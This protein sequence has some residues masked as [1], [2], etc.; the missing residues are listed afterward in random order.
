MQW[1]AELADREL[2]WSQRSALKKESDLRSDRTLVATLEFRT[3]FGTF[4]TATAA[5]GCWTFK[6]V[7]FWRND[8]T[9]RE[10]A[11]DASLAVFKNNTARTCGRSR[12]RRRRRPGAR[13][14]SPG[15]A[16]AAL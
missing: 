2:R 6:R 8:A 13:S 9:V 11:S 16:P 4:A 10:C 1:I 5:D 7:G 15:S 14:H 3:L 12:S